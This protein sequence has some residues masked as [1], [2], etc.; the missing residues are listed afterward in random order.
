MHRAAVNP[1]SAIPAVNIVISKAFSIYFIELGL[2]PGMSYCVIVL[3]DVTWV[4]A[5]RAVEL[6]VR[7]FVRR[8]DRS[9]SQYSIYQRDLLII[10]GA[11][12]AYLAR[13][14]VQQLVVGQLVCNDIEYARQRD[15]ACQLRANAVDYVVGQDS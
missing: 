14:V 3:Y 6:D 9:E 7:A 2:H 13:Q 5:M 10:V 11:Y 8:K 15:L 12:L 1:A 4:S